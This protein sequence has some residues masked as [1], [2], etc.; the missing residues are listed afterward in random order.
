V[1]F[2][3]RFLENYI[4]RAPLALAIERTLEC[5]ILSRQDFQRP[6]LDVGCGDGIFA[7]ILFAEPVDVGIDPDPR[8]LKK[9][10]KLRAYRELIC[11]AGDTIPTPDSSYRTVFSN[12]VLEHIS[13]L[14]PVMNEVFRILQPGG[15]FYFTVPAENFDVHTVLNQCLTRAGLHRVAAQYR[16][17]FNRFWKHYHAYSPVK[18]KSLAENAGF[19]V[20][21]IIR[22]DPPRAALLNDALA[23]FAFPSL[24]LKRLFDRWVLF[25]RLRNI[26]M[27]PLLRPLQTW[28]DK[29]CDSPDGCL[30]FVKAVKPGA[31]TRV[32]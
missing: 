19:S 11:C 27:R 25:P 2:R 29:A 26:L 10:E 13:D 24:C 15:A 4:A 9:A 6:V 32:I 30:V 31:K 17:I 22:Y 1:R 20:D 12:S 23:P 3:D 7:D 21:Q 18:W 28:T 16:K 8:E 14:T 5:K